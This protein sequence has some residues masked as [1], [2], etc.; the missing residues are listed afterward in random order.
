M[1][2]PELELFEKQQACGK[3]F[4]ELAERAGAQ[5]YTEAVTPIVY[6]WREFRYAV[7]RAIVRLRFIEITERRPNH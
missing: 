6:G 4:E 2:S 3:Q 7:V 1:S 5:K